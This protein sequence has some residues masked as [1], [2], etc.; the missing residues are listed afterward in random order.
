MLLRGKTW[1]SYQCLFNLYNA[2]PVHI[3]IVLHFWLCEELDTISWGFYGMSWSYILNHGHCLHGTRTVWCGW[4]FFFFVCLSWFGFGVGFFGWVFLF[5]LVFF[6]KN[7]WVMK[8]MSSREPLDLL[9]SSLWIQMESRCCTGLDP[10]LSGRQT[11]F[12]YC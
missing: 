10:L 6:L 4:G 7:H 5:G 12:C 9:I 1:F 2:Y 3:V 8:L 11:F